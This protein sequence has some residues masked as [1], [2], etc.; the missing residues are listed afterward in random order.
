MSKMHGKRV[1]VTAAGRTDSGVHALGQVINFKTNLTS[2]EPERFSLA[3]NS[4][5]PWDVRILSSDK[6]PDQFHARYDAR[7]RT[8]RYNLLTSMVCLPQHRNY[9]YHV[10]KPLDINLLNGYASVITG[11]HD[12]TTFSVPRDASKSRIRRIS[13]AAFFTD[14]PFVVFT[15]TGTAFLW[16]MVRSLV[17]TMLDLEK[18]GAEP[19]NFREILESKD[20]KLAGVTAPPHGLFLAKVEYEE[21]HT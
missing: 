8:Y 21:W 17:G 12:F 13:S 4:S 14:G 18:D 2:I 6:A 16:K 3:L 15:I 11:E 10:R 5:L 19:A 20:R 1:P 9:C 7:K